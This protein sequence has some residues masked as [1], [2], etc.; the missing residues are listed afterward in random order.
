MR[1]T[2][3]VRYPYMLAHLIFLSIFLMAGSAILYELLLASVLSYLLG[4]TVLYF[5]LTI[6]VFL[7]ALGLGAWVSKYIVKNTLQR[8][9]TLETLLGILGGCAVL[10]IFL[11][12][13]F[14]FG[15][16]GVLYESR[17]P[18]EAF[19]N[20]G[21][22][23]F[24]FH[25]FSFLYLFI[26]GVLVGIELPIFTR[27]VNESLVLKEALAR[28]F[29]WDYLGS[30]AAS[31]LFPL[32]LLPYLG[33]LRTGF[34][35]G[36]TNLLAAAILARAVSSSFS[37]LGKILFLIGAAALILGFVF[38]PV[39]EEFFVRKI[40]AENKVLLRQTSPYQNIILSQNQRGRISL[41]LNWEMQF[42]SGSPE[43]EYHETFAHPVLS[44]LRSRTSP[45]KSL[46]DRQ[47]GDFNS[48]RVLILGGGDGL[49]LRE[50]WKY[51]DIAQVT[52]VDID[53][54]MTELAKSHPVLSELNEFSMRDHRLDIVHADAFSWLLRRP[55]NE[56]RFDVI[57]IDFP[58]ATDDALKRLYSQEFYLLVKRNLKED[59]IAMVQANVL[60]SKPHEVIRKTLRQAGFHILTLH[61]PPA[62]STPDPQGMFDS[63]FVAAS[64][65]LTQLESLY[66]ALRSRS[67]SLPKNLVTLNQDNIHQVLDSYLD[68]GESAS[69]LPNS[70]FRPVYFGFQR[71][72]FTR[73][74]QM[75]FVPK[76]S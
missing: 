15:M 22:L 66:Q 40:F 12:Y 69:A 33:F 16:L 14:L 48:I 47:A 63:A 1:Y 74:L 76:E 50:L 9:L 26:I 30:L 18:V 34:L 64:P 67:L 73:F 3:E 6:G 60:P 44:F 36:I 31:V 62:K 59:G 43:K 75:R 46:P 49:L 32:L 72:L 23:E 42:L 65:S 39:I 21:Q 24:F 10:F 37:W 2:I 52:M 45:G 29:F 54:L 25:G 28:V 13:S 17:G 38:S 20:S 53:P 70:L 11:M 4:A 51:P 71:G 57:F 35:V 5:S 19:L 27:L 68:M 56:N 41:F 61:S 8:F 58:D 7:F 55:K